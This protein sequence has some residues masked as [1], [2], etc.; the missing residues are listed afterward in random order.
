MRLGAGQARHVQSSLAGCA[1][2]YSVH[3]RLWQG[4][5]FHHSRWLGHFGRM[6]DSRLPKRV[7]F[8]E[9]LNTRRS[10]SPKKPWRNIVTADLSGRC[11]TGDW[12][13]FA[14]DRRHWRVMCNRPQPGVPKPRVFICGCGRDFPW[15]DDL[16]RHRKNC[17][18]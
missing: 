9:G 2:A 16:T 7:L 3:L 4:V 18:S 12:C 15:P 13:D 14:Q 10:H 1:K 8:A 17:N 6:E 5:P 11:V